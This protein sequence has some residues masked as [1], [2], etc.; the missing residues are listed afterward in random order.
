[1]AGSLAILLGVSSLPVL[2]TAQSTITTSSPDRDSLSRPAT[3]T[4]KPPEGRGSKSSRGIN[5]RGRS[6][7]TLVSKIPS[8]TTTCRLRSFKASTRTA[9]PVT[10]TYRS[11]KYARSDPPSWKLSARYRALVVTA[12]SVDDAVFDRAL[13]LSVGVGVTVGAAV[14]VGLGVEDDA[15]P[16]KSATSRQAVAMNCIAWFRQSLN[17]NINFN[18]SRIAGSGRG[19]RTLRHTQ[20]KR[21]YTSEL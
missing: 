11:R 19:F 17:L 9:I 12:D 10:M 21:R 16:D 7:K 1:M 20:G 4:A 3:S 8:N 6:H 14:A 5:P 2:S 13:P 18:E 15:H